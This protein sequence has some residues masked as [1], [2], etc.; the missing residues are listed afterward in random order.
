[1]DID[2]V[3]LN[4]NSNDSVDNK[5]KG[6]VVSIDLLLVE[7]SEG[8]M[9]LPSVTTI[10]FYNGI[11]DEEYLRNRVLK[12]VE[13]NPWLCGSLVRDESLQKMTLSYPTFLADDVFSV[14]EISTIGDD[15]SYSTNVKLTEK[16]A[17]KKGM[18]C[19]QNPNELLF[20]V[21]LIKISQEKFALIFSISHVIADGYTFYK[22]YSMLD[23]NIPISSMIVSRVHSFLE[24]LIKIGAFDFAFWINSTGFHLR[25]KWI[26]FFS[27]VK[28]DRRIQIIDTNWIKSQ[29]Q[30]ESTNQN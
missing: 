28:S 11:E 23:K 29:K 16:F 21:T 18:I 13:A 30:I 15:I 9:E 2:Q 26:N 19:L 5:L 10:T 24:S 12:I 3:D 17:V 6:N 1:M 22:L 7:N 4:T 27:Q 14:S 25:R 20:R 8:Y